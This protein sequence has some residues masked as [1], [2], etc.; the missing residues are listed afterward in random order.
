MMP[1]SFEMAAWRAKYRLM[2]VL[3]ASTLNQALVMDRGV[4]LDFCARIIVP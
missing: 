4:D 3:G 2:T 1:Q